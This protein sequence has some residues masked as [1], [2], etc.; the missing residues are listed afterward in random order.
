MLM[1]LSTVVG[2]IEDCCS[3]MVGRG[4]HYI[5]AYVQGVL[6]RRCVCPSLCGV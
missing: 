2:S 1:T 6:W 5:L 4:M 3:I